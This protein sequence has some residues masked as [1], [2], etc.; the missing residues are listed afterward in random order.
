M[1]EETILIDVEIDDSTAAAKLE[2]LSSLF[3]ANTKQIAANKAA[4][5]DLNKQLKDGTISEKQ[6]GEQMI[7]LQSSTKE[8]TAQNN[9]LV[10]SGRAIVASS[11]EQTNALINEGGS[12]AAMR[13]EVTLLQQQYSQLTKAER[14]SAGG[15]EMLQKLQ[16]LEEET[17]SAEMEMRNFKTNIGNYPSA[18]ANLVPGFTQL[19]NLVRGLGTDIQTL[20]SGGT[21]GFATIA[22]S[23]K[24]MGKAFI[25]PPVGVVVAIIGAIVIVIK[26]VVEAFK[27]NDAAMTQLKK[28]VAAFQPVLTAIGK[29]FDIVAQAV[30]QLVEW[31]VQAVTWITKMNPL[32]KLFKALFPEVAEGMKEQAAAAQALVE[33]QD[34]LEDQE[35][36]YTVNKAKREAE[37]AKL[38]TEAQDKEKYTA[39]ERKKMLKEAIDLEEQNLKD[40]KA[41]T[42]EKLRLFDLE[43]KQ[44]NDTSDEMK[45]KRAELVA[46]LYKADQAYYEGTKRLRA[47]YIQ[48]EKEIEEEEK[49]AEEERKKKAAEWARVAKERRERAEKY[50]QE[51]E[52][53]VTSAMKEGIEKQIRLAQIQTQ[54]EIEEIR[55]RLKEEKGLTAK[56]KD[57]LAALIKQKEQDLQRDIA[58]IRKINAEEAVKKAVAAETERINLEI[59]TYKKGSDEYYTLRR[60]ANE[61]L[62]Q[63]ELANE[64]LTAQEKLNIVE[65]YRQLNEQDEESRRAEVWAKERRN[66]E[67]QWQQRILL[68]ETNEKELASVEYTIEQER[69][70]NLEA[71]DAESKARMFESEQAYDNAVIEQKNKVYDAQQRLIKQEADYAREQI[72]FASDILDSFESVLTDLGGDTKAFAVFNKIIALANA[73]VSLGEAIAAATAS[74]AA[75]DPYTLAFRIAAAAASVA[76]AFTS[77][78]ATINKASIPETPKFAQG[79]VVGGVQYS[80]DKVV[81]RLNSGEMILTREQQARLFALANGAGSAANLEVMRTAMAEAVSSLP[82]P[83]LVYTEFEDFTRRTIKIR[84]Y[85]NL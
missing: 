55:K 30:A 1:A 29:V 41:I 18:L 80:G 7:L 75:G 34:K 15:Q 36:E 73:T 4:M 16:S 24:A 43:A 58:N 66:L 74:A 31:I 17:R 68:A 40:A 81:G 13:R 48:A 12:I 6:Y 70:A 52:D 5:K 60:K 46:A 64:A 20:A 84:E 85:E 14:E 37:I 8:L 54:R 19:Q 25:T 77:V 23:A 47:S 72:A 2:K 61:R 21:K 83:T 59:A 26:K 76:A 10:K 49:K 38:R 39:E 69:L 62:M 27:K 3:A 11:E 50:A 78:F 33:A 57:T 35:R 28:A 53:A 71:L 79:G 63:L 56:E 9:E 45:N 42:A 51:L 22:T 82:A 44:N 67:G 32:T 65:R